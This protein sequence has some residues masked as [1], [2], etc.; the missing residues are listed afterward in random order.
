MG[1]KNPTL[2]TKI[3]LSQVIEEFTNKVNSKLAI[4]Q[5]GYFQDEIFGNSGPIPPRVGEATTY[6]IMWQAKNYYNEM[7]DVKLK[8]TLPENVKLTGKIFPEEQANKF[9]FDSQSRELVWNIGDLMVAQGVLSA[10]PNIAFQVALTPSA[11]QQGQTPSLISEVRI[12]GQDQW[13]NEILEA[14]SPAINTTLPG[15]ETINN[16]KGIVQ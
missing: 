8:A 11:N 14:K 5:K 12:T 6:T 3:Y 16:E 13:T 9:T 10:A 2:Q 1:D 4:L 15:D 7:K